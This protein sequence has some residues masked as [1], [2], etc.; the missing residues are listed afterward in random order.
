MSSRLHRQAL[1]VVIAGVL[2]CAGAFWW[3]A[4]HDESTPFLPAAGPADWIVY[5][6]PPDTT[7][8]PAMYTWAVFRRSFTVP[9][10]PSTAILTV[11][12]FRQG[13]V[14]IN[15]HTLT[16]LHLSDEAWKQPHRVD[17]AERLRA[18]ENEIS[19]TVSNLLGPPA[20]S[21][22]L[23][24]DA[25]NLMT[26]PQWQVSLLG[27]V[28]QPAVLAAKPRVIRPGNPLYG[29]ESIAKSFR[30]SRRT[31]LIILLGSAAVAVV[32]VSLGR[33]GSPRSDKVKQAKASA[34]T[35][36][37]TAPTSTLPPAPFGQALRDGNS[38]AESERLGDQRPTGRADAMEKSPSGPPGP[39]KWIASAHAPLM[40]FVLIILAWVILFA[41]NLPQLSGLFG[42]DRDGHQQYIDFILQQKALPL[43]DQ[44]WQMYQPPLYYVLSA[45]IIGPL[46]W[47]ASA[48][49]AMLVLRSFSVVVGIAHLLLIFLCLRLVFPRQPSC[50]VVGLLIAGFLPANLC[51]SHHLTNENLAAALVTAALYFS[52]RQLRTPGA[53]ARLAVG[54]GACLGLALLTKFS[55]VLAVPCVLVALAW[56]RAGMPMV[57]NI[58]TSVSLALVSLLVVCGW[59]FA[60]V[61]HRFGTPLIGNWD[62]RLPFAWWQDPGY[63]TAG[64]YEHFGEALVRP[65]FSSFT[66][67][68]DGLYSTL[69]G[70]G[71][72]SASALMAFR[73]QWNYD[74]M[75]VGY[76]LALFTTALLLAGAAILLA[77]FLRRPTAEGF[78]LLGLL[79]AFAVGIT[80][81]TLRVASYA[82]VKAFYALPALLPLCIL[83]VLGWDWI[84]HRSR[85]LRA[86]LWTGLLTWAATSY[87]AFWIRSGSPTTVTARGY[88]LSEDDRLPEAVEEYT[89]A[90]RLDPNSIDARVGLAKVLNKLGRRDEAWQQVSFVL[91]KHPE[92]AEAH[93]QAAGLLGLNGR[94]D[95]AIG[96]LREALKAAPD[97]PTAYEQLA[98]CYAMLNHPEEVADA[99]QQ[100]LRITPYKP[101]LHH[102][103][104]TAAEATGHLTN[105]I[106]HLET[107]LALNPKWPEVRGALANAL[108]LSGQLERAAETYEQAVRDKPDDGALHYALALT[109]GM[110]GKPAQAA[111]EYRVVLNLQ[112]NN[113]EALNNLAWILAVS[114]MDTVRN[115]AEAV[116]LAE[117]ACELT[118]QREPLLLGTLAAA[119]AEAGRYPEAVETAEKARTLALG[120]G[121]KE[122]ADRNSELRTLY[123]AGKPYR[124]PGLRNR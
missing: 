68:A 47:A 79:G 34:A 11:R 116:R 63:H 102:M 89:Q 91:Q 2:V 8:H 87:V 26:E 99:C 98:A 92:A 4:R 80:L 123:R 117:R 88:G 112:P 25:L 118:H 57:R 42:F 124:D 90:L 19:V 17:V 93:T 96:H 23:Q 54:A 108:A 97:H 84:A 28:W 40:V 66:S 64:W 20:L 60:R 104:A 114:S 59:H 67:F 24:G 5:P 106:D 37:E 77:R 39:R 78:L 70:D 120:A 107:A 50:Q 16:N 74:L 53:E 115:G 82:Q 75:N 86:I 111:G 58:V 32:I 62:P 13:A 121:L 14:V 46:G 56:P 95:E 1:A 33:R 30:A 119:Y 76:L 94:Y 81:M 73:P 18:G 10:V 9:R 43:A 101:S 55:A 29:G 71:L 52:L 45:L 110:Q 83:A 7:P 27:A 65:L 48:D 41:N 51:L 35:A 3:I 113:V 21:L 109:L 36:P 100:G 44:G 15:G 72:C 122:I 38:S 22:A 31:F 61:W 6:N 105:A 103:L 12:A 85:V 69:W 49:S